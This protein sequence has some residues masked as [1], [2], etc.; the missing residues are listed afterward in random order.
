MIHAID[1]NVVVLSA[2]GVTVVGG[3][4]YAFRVNQTD[5]IDELYHLIEKAAPETAYDG[6]FAADVKI[7]IVLTGDMKPN[8]NAK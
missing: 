2:S 6:S 3:G 5:L 1:K 7:E 4:E 8:N